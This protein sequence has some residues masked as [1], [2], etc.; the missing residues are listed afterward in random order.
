MT[1]LRASGAALVRVVGVLNASEAHGGW[2]GSGRGIGA[3]RSSAELGG[4]CEVAG[5]GGSLGRCSEV[6]VTQ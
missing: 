4:D 2:L 5:D 3:R 1:E 6:E